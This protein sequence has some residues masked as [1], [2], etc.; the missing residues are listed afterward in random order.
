MPVARRWA[1]LDHAAVAPLPAPTAAALAEFGRQASE[2]GDVAWP[3]WA[4]DLE[5][6]RCDA[7][8]W[9]GAGSDEITLV[10]NTTYGINIVAEGYPWSPG[11]N[12]VL[13][14]GEFPSNL[15]PWLNQQDRGVEVRVVE[16]PDGRVDLD[17]LAAAIDD[18]TRIVSA[19]WV[20]YASG[21]RLDVDRL[22]QIAHDR[23]ALV[24]LDA[25]QGLGV[26][27]LDLARTEV[28]FLAADGHK[29]MLGPEGAGLAFIRRRH[30]PLLRCRTVGWNSVRNRHDFGSAQLQLRDDAARY[31]GG[32]ANM[33]GLMAMHASLQLFWQTIRTCGASAISDRVLQLVD[34]ADQLLRAAGA[35]PRTPPEGHRSGILTFDVPEVEPAAIRRAALEAKVVVSCR[36]GGVRAS[37]HAYNNEDDLQRLADVVAACRAHRG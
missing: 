37:I 23:G 25:I 7:A 8:E 24:F 18:S 9:L 36:G 26:F 15:L 14:A 33:A 28:D 30:L 12:V 16:A 22:V 6:M 27:P 4:G 19:S 11:D 2:E 17:Q 32:S 34:R 10:P 21:Y 29:W 3:Q 35:E 20:G 1:Y 5:Q 13:P 31:E